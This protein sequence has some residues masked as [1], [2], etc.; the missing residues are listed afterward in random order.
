MDL[1]GVRAAF[2]A[3]GLSRL[4][5]DIGAITMPSIRLMTTPI[6]ESRLNTGASKLGGHPDLPGG[7]NWPAWKGLPQ[8]FIAQIRL[9][10]VKQ[11]DAGGLLPQTGM[12]WFFYDA[13]Q[14]TYGADPADR[15]GWSILYQEDA[16]QLQRAAAP[17]VLPASAQF[18]A[19]SIR[20]A[21]EVTL[22]QTPQLDISSFDWT[23]DEQKRYEQLLS[24][25]PNPDDHAALHHRLLGFPNTVQDDMRLQCQLVSHGITD[26]S[27][28]RAAPLKQGA[29]G[30]Q[31]LLQVDSDEQAGMQW[32]DQ[33]LLYYWMTRSDLQGR[34][35]DSSWLILQSD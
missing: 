8:S 19:C 35:F 26:E 20:F 33:G 6:D 4:L 23:A 27:D 34:H 17:A 21:S 2:V 29:M 30:W 32:A 15:G 7:V 31:L 9:D 13:Q 22:S 1:A 14:Q 18:R 12:L 5:K 3:N 25:F 24:T 10:E 16:A 28:P 11:Y